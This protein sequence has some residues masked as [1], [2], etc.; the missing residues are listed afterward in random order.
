MMRIPAGQDDRH[1]MNGTR[2]LRLVAGQYR[3]ALTR[4]RREAGRSGDR[5][6]F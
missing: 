3:R 5:R 2:A 1:V 4:A 6:S